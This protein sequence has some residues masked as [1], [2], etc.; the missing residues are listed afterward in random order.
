MSEIVKPV[1]EP[2]VRVGEKP[3]RRYVAAVMALFYQGEK[4]VEV[5][6]RGRKIYRAV[7]VAEI[8]KRERKCTVKGIK[9][10]TDTF[11]DK[12]GIERR[13]SFIVISM[14]RPANLKS[15]SRKKPLSKQK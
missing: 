14:K 1:V 11:V 2:M 5:A 6:A 3:L 9:V 7:G 12:N 4:Y 10:G 8:L 15:Q 13:K